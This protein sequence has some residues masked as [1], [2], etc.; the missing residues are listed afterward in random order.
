MTYQITTIQIDKCSFTSL[1]T[2]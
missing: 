2:A 1:I